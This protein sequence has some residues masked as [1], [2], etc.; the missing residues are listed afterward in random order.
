MSDRER[1]DTRVDDANVGQTVDFQVSVN[2]TLLLSRRQGVC[3]DV[4]SS[5]LQ[6]D[7]VCSTKRRR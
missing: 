4:V 5:A 2:D 1:E 6:M 3:A 7:E